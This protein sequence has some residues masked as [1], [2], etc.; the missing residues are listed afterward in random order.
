MANG[1]TID[2]L[3]AANGGLA[4]WQNLRHIVLQVDS[5]GG[6]LPVLKGLGRTF[7]QPGVVLVNPSQ[8]SAEFHDYPQSGERA[9][10]AAGGV[11]FHNRAGAV[12][13]DQRRYRETFRGIKKYRRWSHADAVYFFGYALA[14]YLS[15]PFML[16]AHAT[17]IEAWQ[18]G[19]HVTARFPKTIDTHSTSQQFW[20][21]RDGLL[22]RHDYCADVVGWW[23][24][25]SHFNSEYEVMAGLP[26]AT[27]RQVYGRLFRAVTPIPVLSARLQPLEVKMLSET[28][29]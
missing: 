11:Q 23:A 6:P 13:F 19:V 14:T 10:F 18:S 22:V 26:I 1:H 15:V 9:I 7:T 20:F 29:V 27:R 21:D 25:G 17:R 16:T 2:D 8:W 3:I 24:T 28:A 4:L 12:T 5:L